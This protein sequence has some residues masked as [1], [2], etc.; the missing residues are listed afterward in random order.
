MPVGPDGEAHFSRMVCGTGREQGEAGFHERRALSD[1]EESE[2][3]RARIEKLQIRKVWLTA[4]HDEPR[5]KWYVEVM[6]DTND[7]SDPKTKPRVAAEG[8]SLKEA[9]MNLAD[10]INV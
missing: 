7:V 10:K 3:I 5:S 4:T 9:L 2:R 1:D 6:S 8:S